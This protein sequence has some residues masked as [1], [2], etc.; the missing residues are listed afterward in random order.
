LQ[1]LRWMQV[2]AASIDDGESGFRDTQDEWVARTDLPA[3]SRVL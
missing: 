1:T 3:E 2:G